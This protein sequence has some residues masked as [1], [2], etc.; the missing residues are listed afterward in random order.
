[1]ICCGN[2]RAGLENTWPITPRSSVVPSNTK[3]SS[4]LSV[5]LAIYATL[6]SGRTSMRMNSYDSVLPFITVWPSP[7]IMPAAGAVHC[8]VN[9]RRLTSPAQQPCN[10]ASAASGSPPGATTGGV[11]TLSAG[12]D[13]SGAAPDAAAPGDAGDGEESGGA[14]PA[15]AGAA[16]AWAEAGAAIAPNAHSAV[17]T[18]RVRTCIGKIRCSL[19]PREG[20]VEQQVLRLEGQARAG[21]HRHREIDGAARDRGAHVGTMDEIQLEQAQE[22]RHP[23]L[24]DVDV[25]VQVVEYRARLGV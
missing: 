2:S 25:I 10:Q 3:P 7:S 20:Q 19:L 9:L 22:P 23:L 11:M 13:V 5:G 16:G 18:I 4:A 6:P 15:A 14:A 12:L 24:V 8:S 17:V 21:V 1:M